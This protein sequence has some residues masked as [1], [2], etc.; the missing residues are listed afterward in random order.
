MHMREKINTDKFLPR[1]TM[2]QVPLRS[3][4]TYVALIRK[5][6]HYI[7]LRHSNKRHIKNYYMANFASSDWS[8]PGLIT[9]GTD[10]DGPVTFALFRF[11]FICTLFESVNFTNEMANHF[12]FNKGSLGLEIG[13]FYDSKKKQKSRSNYTTPK[14]DYENCQQ[15]QILNL[16]VRIF[17]FCF[18][19]HKNSRTSS[20]VQKLLTGKHTTAKPFSNFYPNF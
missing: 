10:P 17:L 1:S 15:Q 9:Y 8:I 7:E 5:S 18:K 2:D 20:F 13:L 19:T 14:T 11:C 16:S 12:G 3:A 6:K 4:R